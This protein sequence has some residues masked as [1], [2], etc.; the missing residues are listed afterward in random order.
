[1][2]YLISLAIGGLIVLASERREL[3]AVYRRAGTFNFGFS[4]LSRTIWTA[5]MVYIGIWATLIQII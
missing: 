1:M 5:I 2:M 3:M 4:F